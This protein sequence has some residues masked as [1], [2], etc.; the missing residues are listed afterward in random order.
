VAQVMTYSRE[1]QHPLMC[2]ME[3]A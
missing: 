2:T 3:E 1:N